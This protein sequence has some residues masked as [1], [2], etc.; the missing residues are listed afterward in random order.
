MTMGRLTRNFTL[1]ALLFSL[2][3][4][5][6]GCLKTGSAGKDPNVDYYT[7]TMHPSVKSQKP[8]DK[9]PICS[10]D[11]VPVMKKGAP[12][13]GHDHQHGGTSM[14]MGGETKAGSGPGFNEF[15]VP[16]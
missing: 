16:V 12:A 4:G 13:E 6:A 7:C 2:V 1:V 11:L 14:P 10:M 3:W 8:D 5:L 9:C 15:S